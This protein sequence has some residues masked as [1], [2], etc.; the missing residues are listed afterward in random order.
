MLNVFTPV[1]KD[2]HSP[3]EVKATAICKEHNGKLMAEVDNKFLSFTEDSYL[4]KGKTIIF[5]KAKNTKTICLIRTKSHS[6]QFP[7]STENF[8]PI[9]EGFLY[10]GKI[11]SVNGIEYFDVDDTLGNNS[12]IR[13]IEYKVKWE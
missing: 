1:E 3:K 10:S 4:T 6:V 7:E 8:T 13:S 9:R 12:N 11:V 5:T 2:I